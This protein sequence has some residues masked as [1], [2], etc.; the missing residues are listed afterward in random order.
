LAPKE[1]P[2]TEGPLLGAMGHIHFDMCVQVSY[3]V[4]LAV[5]TSLCFYVPKNILGW[6]LS[7]DELALFFMPA[8]I[9]TTTVNDLGKKVLTYLNMRRKSMRQPP[10]PKKKIVGAA[11]RRASCMA[12]LPRPGGAQKVISD[13]ASCACAGRP[14]G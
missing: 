3:F 5:L 14:L 6:S 8:A 4:Q 12:G 10:P 9:V 11:T 2:F 13:Q 1:D 7:I